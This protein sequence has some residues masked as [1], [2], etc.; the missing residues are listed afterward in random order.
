MCIGGELLTWLM[1]V[2]SVHLWSQQ[3][4]LLRFLC[5]VKSIESVSMLLRTYHSNLF[6]T[7]NFIASTVLIRLLFLSVQMWCP[8]VSLL[9]SK[10]ISILL[11]KYFSVTGQVGLSRKLPYCGCGGV[12]I[13]FDGA[14]MGYITLWSDFYP[15]ACGVIAAY[16][17]YNNCAKITFPWRGSRWRESLRERCWASLCLWTHATRCLQ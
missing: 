1:A 10:H 7:K 2:P 4:L 17:L 3:V 11:R 15:C 9:G 8:S 12:K 6:A 5:G 13:F 16:I 14:K